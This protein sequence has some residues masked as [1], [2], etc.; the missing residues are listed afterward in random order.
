MVLSLKNG[1]NSGTGYNLDESW[2]YNTKWNKLVTKRQILCDFT[3]MSVV[4][5]VVKFIETE[6]R[7]GVSRGWGCG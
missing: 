3:Y 4:N 7:M 1:G 5:T 2:G 6:S